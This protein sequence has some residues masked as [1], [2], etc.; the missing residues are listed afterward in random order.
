VV[1]NMMLNAE[2]PNMNRLNTIGRTGEVIWQ[3]VLEPLFK[4]GNDGKPI[5]V[6]ATR[7]EPSSDVK[8]WRFYLREGVQ[9]HNGEKFTSQQVVDTVNAILRIKDTAIVY[10]SLPF[11]KAI[12]IDDHTVDLQFDKPQPLLPINIRQLLIYPSAIARD[13]PKLADT[14]VIGT[15]PYQFVDWERGLRIRL[16]KF[17][18]YWGAKPQIDEVNITFR[19]EPGVRL[20]A[21]QAGEADWVI[22]LLPEMVPQAPKTV[23]IPSTDTVWMMFDTYLQKDNGGTSLLADERLRM[24]L[25][26]AIDRK[27]LNHLFADRAT[28]STGQ[29][30]VPGDFG[31]SPDMQ[32]E[33]RGYDLEKAKA[34]VRD[35]GAVGKQLTWVASFDRFVKDREII[36]AVIAMVEQTGLKINL[37]TVSDAERTTYFRTVTP[38]ERKKIADIGMTSSDAVLEVESRGA[39]FLTAKGSVTKVRDATLEA[40]YADALG[41]LD[42]QKRGQKVAAAWRYAYGKA[43]YI[44][45]FRIPWIFGVAKN[46]EWSPNITGIPFIA[47]MKFTGR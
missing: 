13:D 37:L 45:L 10:L 32:G 30:A 38:D 24:A 40:L 44:A 33:L 27:A 15:G 17:A 9:F 41:E 47:D 21:L 1:L 26:Y 5:P 18:D 31:Y 23:T 8:T 42:F 14:V 46:L 28:L 35:A 11:S 20:A 19:K 25:D 29:F 36:E 43:Y 22:D 34:L 2:E 12:A 4:V 3:N 39:S 7:M 6:L 16:K